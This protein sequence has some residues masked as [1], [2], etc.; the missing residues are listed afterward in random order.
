MDESLL[1]EIEARHPGG[2]TSVEILSLFSAQGIPLTEAT[3]RK[4]VQ[5]G[6]LPRSIRVGKKGKHQG[7]RG[8][9]PVSVV[10]QIVRIKKMMSESYTIEQIQQEFLFM[11]SDLQLLERT[12]ASLFD[13]VERVLKQR[14]SE[15]T[16]QAVAREVAAARALGKD[17]VVRL[18]A[19]EKKLT[20][21]PRIDRV[22]AS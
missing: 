6:L 22:A 20:S 2:L 16:V 12:L 3:L 13:N 4:Y 15:G 14:K 9:Y 8:I 19:I 5:Q 11:R 10:R 18:L 21:R 1:A 7:S 17:L